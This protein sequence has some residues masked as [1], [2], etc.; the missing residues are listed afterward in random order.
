[1][2]F[3]ILSGDDLGITLDTVLKVF[4]QLIIH[5]LQKLELS[6]GSY[7]RIRA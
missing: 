7:I 4:T 3:L 1:M 6:K 5:I 2:E